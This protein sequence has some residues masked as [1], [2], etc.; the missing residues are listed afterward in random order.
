[1]LKTAFSEENKVIHGRAKVTFSDSLNPCVR[2]LHSDF[3]DLLD[4]LSDPPRD[5]EQENHDSQTYERTN[6]EMH[7]IW[8][9]PLNHIYA[10]PTKDEIK[11]KHGQYNLQWG[12]NQNEQDI[13][14]T[15]DIP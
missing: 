1:M 4:L 6:R 11:E 9:L 12:V 3:L 10:P 2:L 5:R 15:S 14:S 8:I 13:F 7:Q